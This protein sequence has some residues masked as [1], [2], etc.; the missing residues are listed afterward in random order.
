L[1]KYGA[2]GA[3][4]WATPDRLVRVAQHFVSFWTIDGKKLAEFVVPN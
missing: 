1:P 4:F 3:V 2:T